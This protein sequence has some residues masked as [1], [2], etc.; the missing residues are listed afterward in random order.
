MANS[1]PF[2]S[3]FSG[4]VTTTGEDTLKTITFEDLIAKGDESDADGT[5]TAFV[6]TGVTSGTLRIGADAASATAYDPLTNNIIDATH[7]AFWKPA[8]DANG[9]LD[10]FTVVAQ[11]NV[12]AQ[13]S[14]PVQATVEVTPVNDAPVISREDSLLFDKSDYTSG[15]LPQS[16]TVADLNADGRIDII[17]ADGNS[18]SVSVLLGNGDGTFAPKQDIA[19]GSNPVSVTTADVNRDGKTDIIVLNTDSGNVSVLL[20]NGDGSFSARTDYDVDHATGSGPLSVT[21]ADVNGD[22]YPDIIVSKQSSGLSVLLNDGSGTFIESGDYFMGNTPFSV[23]ATDVNGDTVKD[24]VTANYGDSSVSVFLGNGDGTFAEKIDYTTGHAPASIASADVNGDGLADIITANEGSNNVSVLLNEGGG[25]F[26]SHVEYGTGDSPE[27]V[28]IA[29]IN[30]DGYADIVTANYRDNSVSVLLGKGDGTFAEKLDYAAGNGPVSVTAA[31][32]DSDGK[33]DIIVANRNNDTVSVLVNDPRPVFTTS[34]TEQ[35]PVAVSSR[36]TISDPEG[37]DDWN[38]GKLTVQITANAGA[39]DTLYL[40]TAD[41]GG[42]GIWINTTGNKLM[43]GITE[44]GAANASSVTGGTA[45]TFTFNASATNALVQEV[46]RA[47]MF[48]NPG[49]DP[50]ANNRDVTFTATDTYNASSSSVQTITVTTVNDAPTLTAFDGTVATT[51]ED[52][53][54]AITF[55]DLASNSN[56]ADADGSVTAFV[57]QGVTSGTLL[58][59]SDKNSATPY[60]PSANNI[61]DAAHN[62]YWTPAADANGTLDAFTVIAKDDLGAQSSAPVQAAVSVTPVNDAPDIGRESDL[63]F[64]PPVSYGTG[65]RPAFVAT[66]DLNVDGKAD[67]IVA[68]YSDDSVSVLLNQGDGTF[69]AASTYSTGVNPKS[70]ATADVN[71][72]GKTDIIVGNA[73][74]NSVSV[75]LNDGNG[76]FGPQQQFTVSAEAAPSSVTSADVNGDGKIDIITANLSGNSVSVLLGNGNGTFAD[77]QEFAAGM[78]TFSVTSADVNGDN[79]ADIVAA[80]SDSGTVSVL[81]GNGD[82]TFDAQKEY[83]IAGNPVSV[84]SADVNGDG[85]ADIVTASTQTGTVSVLLGKGD[86]TFSV[87][88][89]YAAGVGPSG[90][91]VLDVNSDGRVDLVV[92]DYA[93]DSVG[94]LLNQGDGTF[95]GYQEFAAGIDPESVAIADMNADGKVDIITADQGGDTVSVLKNRTSRALVTPFVEQTPVELS[96]KITISDPEGNAEWNGGKLNL[97]ITSNAESADMLYLPTTDPGDGGIWL[98]INSNKLMAGT[99]AIG[100]ADATSVSGGTLWIFTFNENATNALVQDVARAVMFNNTS[101]DPGTDNREITFTAT[102]KHGASSSSVQTI[103]VTPVNDAPSGTD[104]TVTMFEDGSYTFAASDFGFTDSDGNSL[105]AVKITTLPVTGMLTLGGAAVS[106]GQFVSAADL[107]VGKLV[108]TPASDASGAPYGSFTFQV[109]DNG[110]TAGGG[111]DLDPAANTLTIDVTPINDAPSGTDK[112]VTMFEN[113]SYTYAASDFGFTDSDG[114]SLQAVKITTLPLAGALTLNGAGVNEGDLVNVTDIN[115]GK[116]V[117]TPEANATGASYSSFTFQVQDNGG[118]ANGGKNLDPLPNTIT[119]NVIQDQDPVINRSID[120]SSF[121]PKA[122]YATANGPDS[123]IS[124]DV[125]GD[126]KTDL[127]VADRSASSISV[128]LGNGD[129]TFAPKQ[130]YTVGSVPMSVTSADVNSDGKADL[131]TANYS[132][133]SVS[134][135]LN[136][137]DGTYAPQVSYA[138]GSN[139]YSVAS[140]DVNGDGKADVVAANFGSNTV[141]VLL[142]N[143]DGT[144]GTKTDIAVGS[145]PASVVAGDVNGDGKTDI[146]VGNYN[147]SSVSVLVNQGDGSYVRTDYGTGAGP[148]SVTTGDVNGDGKLDIVTADK[149]AN[150][151]SVLLGNGDGTFGAKTDYAVGREPY[152]VTITDVNGD[153]KAEIVTA[154]Q[155]DRTV[156]VLMNQGAGTFA[157]KVDFATGSVPVSVTSGDFNS[158]G[159]TDLATA[160]NGS[161]TV[162]VYLN[163]VY[164]TDFIE[165][166]PVKVSDD[167]LVSDPDGDAEW[168]GGSLQVQITS[169]AA[170]ADTLYLPDSN[171]GSS[172][173]W[174]DTNGNKLMAGATEI[175]V[176]NVSS[177]SGGMAWTFTFNANSTNALVQEVARAVTFNNSSDDP[178]TSDREVTFTAT[179]SHNGSVSSVQTIDV[180]A[181][182]DA[183][184]GTDKT[185]TMIEDGSYIFAAADFGF[186]DSD[187][188]SLQA[189][190]ITTLPL[191]GTLTLRGTAVSEGQMVGLGD[192]TTGKLIYTPAAD[193]I[194]NPYASFTFQVQ[195]SGGTASGGQ[196]LDPSANLFTINV[197]VKND[198]PVIDRSNAAS[199]GPDTEYAAG[200]GPESVIAVDV[201]GDG[202]SDVVTADFYGNTVSVLMGNGDGTFGAPVTYAT[203]ENPQM[204]TS[205]DVNG[206]GKADIITANYNGDTV[207]VFL[208]KGDGTFADQVLYDTGDGP[209]SVALADVNGDGKTDIITGNYYGN[210]ISVLLGKGDGTFEAK[211]DYGEELHSNFAAPADVNGDGKVDIVTANLDSN[212]VSVFLNQGDGTY[213]THIDYGTDLTP[214]SV[215]LGDVNGDGWA[216]IVTA[217]YGSTTVSVLLNNGD[218]TFATEVRYETGTSPESVAIADVNLDGKVDLVTANCDANTV[219][220]LLGNGDGTFGPKTDYATGSYPES[221]TVANVNGD[222]KPDIVV[223]NSDSN[224]ISVFENSM[225]Y[226]T[227]ETSFV[228]Q[229]PVAVSDRI[230]ITDPDGDANWNGGALKVQITSNAETADVLYLPAANPGG[231]GIWLDTSS[232]K[233]MSGTTEIGT[234]DAT[235]VSGGTL[236]IFTFNANATNAL[237]Q[238]VARAVLFNNT[239]DDPGTES[240]EITFTA[241]DK[242]DASSSSVQTIDVTAVND[243]P[244]L[245]AFSDSVAST[246]TNEQV[247]ITYADLATKGNES[248]IDGAVT[249]FVVKSVTSGTLKIG[250]DAAS[251]TAYDALTNNTIDAAHKAFWTPAADAEGTLAAFTVVAQ[252]N[253]GAQSSTPVQATVSIFPIVGN[254]VKNNAPS[255]TDKTVTMSEDGNYTFGASDFGFTDS[256]G[257]S[258]LAVKIT[259][260][261]GAGALKLDG[262]AVSA[263]QYVSVSDLNAGKLVY[264]PAADASG[265]PYGSFTF[266]VQDNGGTA[267]GGVDLDQT[268][269]AIT[270]NVTPVND[271]PTGSDKSV[272]ILED[273]SYTF[274]AADFGFSDSDGNTLQAV[275]ITTLPVTGSL[276]LDGI[277]VS[278]GQFVSAADLSSGKLLYTP[279]ADASGSPYGSF[280]FQVQDNGGT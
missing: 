156:S 198:A 49:D 182:N 254:P 112:T 81:L 4:A 266:Q 91:A 195:D 67:I 117:Y 90:L 115:T 279:A 125:N 88:T 20:G 178:G 89:D 202:K 190:K 261:P 39:L 269:N 46:A 85:W 175:G 186:T 237:V 225:L 38:S 22:S 138:T 204:V 157:A 64:A 166:T 193:S 244:T 5:V 153:G 150:K 240:R 66:A 54:V 260:L 167:I 145:S 65:A 99:T 169:N 238:D 80:N 215:T 68:N 271:A 200:N 63:L 75:L 211:T 143:G 229:T 159:M 17:T 168:N 58:I 28:I 132:G 181:V 103:E 245:T 114:N 25:T 250:S 201:N 109:Q 106:E 207:S 59:G 276:T 171:P 234:A 192:L 187:G 208:N 239:S 232:K 180:T 162:S 37:N 210:N 69:A 161:N 111:V 41:P 155:V 142:G 43:S 191:A 55:A 93:T 209:S 280:T 146:I 122:D 116:L 82:G 127:V 26:F 131:I 251:A 12:G 9:T 92:T 129:G 1:N 35:T 256:D 2:F 264:T 228:E 70:A 224:T 6:V 221:V 7:M 158:D 217:N 113:G 183:P 76:S 136:Q 263:S 149:N 27:S 253:D 32:A 31:D 45:W 98:D 151:V 235:S 11:D 160:N 164:V 135:L 176:A 246:N 214:Y 71:G 218:G 216:D 96:D 259:T 83:S 47:V 10:A 62:A 123:V 61:I 139:P 242:Y 196:D 110:G 51:N 227:F 73:G 213:T 265:A 40:P 148:L 121:D 15:A 233:L 185:V 87:K 29:D 107:N 141:S 120:T 205:G 72:D 275:K 3:S 222:S 172:G 57:V 152:S 53:Q 33:L 212:T 30:G 101:D 163:T 170:S 84:I 140:A 194:G 179:D 165:Q 277:A 230:T 94:I 128:L 257:N 154:N 255:G 270:L 177:V 16:V 188:N 19:V 236:W 247:A 79:K 102:D 241:M 34:Y 267:N 144:F 262:I 197:A 78:F 274:A 104:K 189:V 118:T 133:G 258:L 226:N 36:I 252:D 8:A 249:A 219:S 21:S 231:S 206:D 77:Y 173:I 273:G 23:I 100:M 174:L 248:D 243:A 14:T 86:G 44:I 184:S 95:A 147:G 126:G 18:D 74:S 60:D 48:N 130:D 119:I 223:A 137:G 105:K 56:A 52:T 220:V 50:G 134:V 203:G 278:A 42:S 97:Q 108:Y 13:S 199:F 124:A 272:T 268:P 24:L